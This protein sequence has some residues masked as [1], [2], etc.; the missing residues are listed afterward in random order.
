VFVY[1]KLETVF[2]EHHG[3]GYLKKKSTY[4]V[5]VGKADGKRKLGRPRRT[6]ENNMN[7]DNEDI[8]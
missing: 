8:G 1:T 7:I 5:L 2:Y 3:M 4:R 6:W